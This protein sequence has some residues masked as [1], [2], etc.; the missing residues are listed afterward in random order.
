MHLKRIPNLFMAMTPSK[1]LSM[2]RMNL[3]HEKLAKKK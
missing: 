2:A 3:K 1:N